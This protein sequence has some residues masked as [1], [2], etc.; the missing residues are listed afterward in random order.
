MILWQIL[1]SWFR[2]G[3]LAMALMD[4][5][6]NHRFWQV[7]PDIYSDIFSGVYTYLSIYIY[8]SWHIFLVYIY[9]DIYSDMHSDCW[10]CWPCSIFST[11]PRPTSSIWKVLE[12]GAWPCSWGFHAEKKINTDLQ[13]VYLPSKKPFKIH[14]YPLNISYEY[15][16]FKPLYVSHHLFHMKQK[17]RK[18]KKNWEKL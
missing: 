11:T 4:S 3:S 13:F 16:V 12:P 10:V 15:P 2:G 17:L 8:T 1:A 18:T 7:L 9:Y 5:D 14:C 6:T